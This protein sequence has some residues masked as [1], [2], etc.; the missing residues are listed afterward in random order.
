[1]IEAIT[2]PW[3]AYAVLLCST[4]ASRLRCGSWFAPA[5]FV[6]LIWS[7]FTGA[8]LLVVDYPVPAHGVWMLVLLVVA[9]QLG[10]WI[11]H[12]LQPHRLHMDGTLSAG[13]FDPLIVP[14]RRYGLLCTVIA[15]VGCVYFLFTSLDEFGLS[16][17]PI[18]V[19]EVGAHWTRL[20]YDDVLE[21]WSV[22]LLVM[23]LHPAALLGGLLFASSGRR[24]DRVIAVAT[25]SPALIYGVLTGAR[26][27]ILLGMACWLGGY[28]ATLCIRQ[29]AAVEMF[30]IKRVFH[31]SLAAAFL[32]GM[33]VG[34]DSVRDTSWIH[35]V[36]L[37]VHE[38]ELNNYMF[39]SPAAFAHWYAHT[40]ATGAE[41]GARTFAGAFDV[42]HL[43]KRIA[44]RYSETSNVV[45]TEATNVYTSFRGLI[46]DFTAYGAAIA[47]VWI[48]AV[49]GWFY[50][51][52][53]NNPLISLCLLSAFY[54]FFLFSPIVSLFSFNGAVL[55]WVA[56]GLVLLSANRVAAHIPVSIVHRPEVAPP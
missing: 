23:W 4:L 6:G 14:C 32:V 30:T 26:A 9:I 46:E 21:P 22:R 41:W 18:G 33:F 49:G 1:M 44:G 27:A 5:A 31:L 45:G 29:T 19:L 13:I 10:A 55:A 20:R 40:D 50:C 39:G 38:E 52:R 11:A 51:H 53:H 7:F 37:D 34:I 12:E 56:A 16:F 48:G 36:M 24:M 54:G 47:A 28:I 35:D 17:T 8:S 3:P 15:V 43:A 2:S 25:L 42:L